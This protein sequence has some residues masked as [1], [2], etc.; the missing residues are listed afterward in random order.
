MERRRRVA[1]DL[2]GGEC[3]ACGDANTWVLTFDHINGGGV[4]H[5]NR[6]P[7]VRGANISTWIRDNTERALTELQLLCANCH[8]L[9]G[10]AD[11]IAAWEAEH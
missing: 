2:L 5:R 11:V 3:V 1:L 7:Q 10:R 6:N 8:I 4:A 9:K